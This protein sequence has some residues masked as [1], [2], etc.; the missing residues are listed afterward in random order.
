[1]SDI[2]ILRRPG[3]PPS[4]AGYPGLHPRQ[5]RAA[6]MIIERDLGVSLRDGTVIYI[7]LFRPDSGEAVP[8]ILGWGPYGKFGPPSYH[9]F[10]KNGGITAET[11]SDL[12]IFEGP[13]PAFWCAAG[14]AVAIVDPRGTWSSEG[15]AN[16]WGAEQEGDDAYDVIEWLAAQSWCNGRV[17]MS[18]VSYFTII[19]WRAAAA[20][21][22]HLAAINPWEGFR[23]SYREIAYIGGIPDKFVKVWQMTAG[24][25]LRPVEDVW[26]MMEEHPLFDEYWAG[27]IA[28]LS[29]VDIPAYIVASWSDQGLHTRGTIGAFNEIASKD[30]W[31][32]VHGRKKWE[33][34]YRPE[35]LARQKI[36]FDRFL[37]G[38]DNEISQWPRVRLELRDRYYDGTEREEREWPP[39]R[40]QYRS[41]FLDHAS[42][43]LRESAI[44]E[45]SCASYSV[46]S[47]N[48]PQ[49]Y[50]DDR[51]EFD[52][53]FAADTEITGHMK[54]R[55]WVESE[56]SNDLDLFVAIQKFDA[57][58]AYVGFPFF[59][60]QEDGPVALGWLRASH[61]ALDEARS[62]PWQPWHRHDREELLKPKEIVPVDIEI[63]PS[64]TLFRTGERLRLVVQGSDV[65]SYGEGTFTSDHITR[66]AGRHVV[67]AG[68]QYDSHLLVPVTA[69]GRS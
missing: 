60:A 19:Q 40:T 35:S 30:K 65:Y 22:P 25:S 47:N 14:Y 59:S 32:E 68:G 49:S 57:S 9:H 29:K 51:L 28:D 39:A 37:K 24:W 15:E 2:N 48:S 44:V 18:G 64:S 26:A 45:A 31:L 56:G 66:N 1:M 50:H 61:R 17:G 58:G 20:R 5:E 7:D 23:D 10:Y 53:V 63:W 46:D 3:M 36:F 42:R 62:T 38:K 4:E 16:F 41:L 33:Y 13:D 69:D 8:A 21:P 34:Y 55:L 52:H 27:K 43:E 11:S 6:G 12:T 67:H 54:L